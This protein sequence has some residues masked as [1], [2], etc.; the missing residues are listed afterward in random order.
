MHPGDCF[1]Y[2]LKC[3]E[4]KSEVKRSK[5][6]LRVPIQLKNLGFDLLTSVPLG[7][8]NGYSCMERNFLF[9]VQMTSYLVYTTSIVPLDRSL[10]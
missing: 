9:V 7:L 10:C 1:I 8:E 6:E 2:V 3:P 4:S 5:L